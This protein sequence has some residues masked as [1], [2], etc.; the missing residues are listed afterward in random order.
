M[1]GSSWKSAE[2]N[3]DAPME[4]PG[5]HEHGV[6]RSVGDGCEVGCQEVRSANPAEVAGRSRNVAVEIIDRQD[7]ELHLIGWSPGWSLACG[8]AVTMRVTGTFLVISTCRVTSRILATSRVTGTS[9]VTSTS[10]SAGNGGLEQP[11]R[12]SVPKTQSIAIKGLNF[13]VLPRPAK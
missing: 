10:T 3:G 4:V 2:I 11:M 6:L 9:R 13:P 8:V 1:V 12:D 5:R 7:L